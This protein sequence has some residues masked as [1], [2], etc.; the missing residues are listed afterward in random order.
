MIT[1]DTSFRRSVKRR[2]GPQFLS[3]FGEQHETPSD[4][5]LKVPYQLCTSRLVNTRLRYA[6][7]SIN[8]R[9]LVEILQILLLHIT[10]TSIF[11]RK[12]NNRE[13][14]PASATRSL[15]R[16]TEDTNMSDAESSPE[17]RFIFI[18]ICELIKY[19]EAKFNFQIETISGKIGI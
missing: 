17:A 19:R 15:R 9:E 1:D 4:S 8:L 3:L 11:G 2:H 18:N 13:T 14:I 12:L 16:T 5:Y 6:Q 10:T 7:V